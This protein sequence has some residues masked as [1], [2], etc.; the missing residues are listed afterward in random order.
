MRERDLY[1]RLL[2]IQSPWSVQDVQ[3][4]EKEK[5]VEVLIEYSGT[6]KCP[7]CGTQTSRYDSLERSW[8]HLD[9]MQ[10]QTILTAK[11]PRANCKKHGARQ[12]Q[13]PWAP[14]CAGS[15]R[16][17]APGAVQPPGVL[18]SLGETDGEW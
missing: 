4:D 15:A 16:E 17:E 13:V 3:L 9:T 14:R 8:R 2:G 7:E 11:V 18:L 12:V 5:R 6:V 10:Y 1:A